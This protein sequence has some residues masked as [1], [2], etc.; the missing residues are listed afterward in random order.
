MPKNGDK[1]RYGIGVPKTFTRTSRYGRGGVLR[2]ER[3]PTKP[4]G[5]GRPTQGGFVPAG[6]MKASYGTHADPKGPIKGVGPGGWVIKPTDP[7]PL[8]RALP[9]PRKRVSLPPPK[10]CV[11]ADLAEWRAKRKAAPNGREVRKVQEETPRVVNP[12]EGLILDEVA[13]EE[14]PPC[15]R[16][17]QGHVLECG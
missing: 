11:A 16:E 9:K 2:K 12:Q 15:S 4:L 8:A 10:R 14:G 13:R 5:Q 3:L 17:Q 1:P 7:D 6:C